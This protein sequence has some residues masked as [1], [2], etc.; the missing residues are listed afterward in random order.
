[1]SGLTILVVTHDLG[2]AWNVADRLA[3]MYLGRIVEQGRPSRSWPP[4]APLHPRCPALAGG[5]AVPILRGL[6]ER[7]AACFLTDESVKKEAGPKVG[8]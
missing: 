4:Q 6:G 7:H 8:R 2:L 1:V 3:V 5:E